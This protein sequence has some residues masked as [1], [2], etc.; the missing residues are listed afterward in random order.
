MTNICSQA[1]IGVVLMGKMWCAIPIRLRGVITTIKKE[2]RDPRHTL[3]LIT[4]SPLPA[5]PASKP[6]TD[7]DA[8]LQNF[9]R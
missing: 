4:V 6:E 5:D 1:S 9:G 7:L 8:R 3:T 2:G